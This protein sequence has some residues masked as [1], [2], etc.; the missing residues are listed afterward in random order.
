ML[1]GCQQTTS[2]LLVAEA[3]G[4][5]GNGNEEIR[6]TVVDAA[7]AKASKGGVAGTFGGFDGSVDQIERRVSVAQPRPP[8]HQNQGVG[9]ADVGAAGGSKSRY[10]RPPRGPNRGRAGTM[11][12]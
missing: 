9:E 8:C 3:P 11:S 7:A 6:E 10:S 12:I 2:P 1:H 4:E 5:H